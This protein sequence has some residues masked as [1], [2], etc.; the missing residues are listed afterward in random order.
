MIELQKQRQIKFSQVVKQ[1]GMTLLE[2]LVA[3]GILA[4]ISSMAFLS[5]DT[6]IKSKASLQLVTEELNQ[7]N[8][9]QFQLQNDIQMAITSN[10]VS[11]VTTAPEFI[12]NTQSITLLRYRNNTV[13]NTR[14]QRSTVSQ[15]TH[16]TNKSSGLIRVRWYVR[17]D[18]WFR[19]IQSAASPLNSNQWQ[20]RPMLSLESLNCSYLD[21]NGIE[22]SIWPNS[23]LQ[24][25][26]LPEMVS[27]QVIQ[28][29]GQKS[30]LKLVPWQRAGWL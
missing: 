10:Q 2:L 1:Q 20:E 24:N 12:A 16:I 14:A 7:F 23:Q 13:V 4:V 21:L 19:A 30:V 22:R 27:C 8:L 26:Q 28:D 17:N 6:L 9:A 3:T 29:N 25:S 15:P 5:I 18:Q 11:A